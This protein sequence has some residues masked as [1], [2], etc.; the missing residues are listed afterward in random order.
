MNARIAA[1]A[2]SLPEGTLTNEE[3]ARGNPDWSP[4]KILLKTGIACRHIAAP[5]DTA[6]DLAERAAKELFAAGS[7]SP[8]DIDF[9]LLCTQSPDYYL[10]A[11]ACILQDRLGVPKS[12]G[13]L[14]FN[15][16]CS[17]YVY[18]LSLAKGLIAAGIARRVLLLTA[19]TYSRYIEPNDWSTRSLFGDGAAAT[20][21]EA[22]ESEGIGGF[23]LG[24]DGSG[25][26]KLVVR[27][28]AHR[29]WHDPEA[30]KPHLEMSGPDIFSFA[31]RTVPTV[32]NQCLKK[33]GLEKTDIDV[34]AL[35]QANKFMLDT[36][37]KAIRVAP[38]KLPIRMV[39]CGNTVSASLPI[40]LDELL[41]DG[42]L[43][44]GKRA[45]L[46]GF[47][48]GLSWGAVPVIF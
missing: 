15:Q 35:H 42:T 11:T 6:A 34:F 32:V 44:P 30:T 29:N 38:E 48:V 22:C 28:G 41:T 12:A 47:G 36:L 7:C 1:I 16:G 2:T 37:C 21:V 3:L 14:D 9:V 33:A 39:N 43:G 27:N 25:W 20:L 26:D 13:A 10:P 4:E 24:T 45:L 18:G 46:V 19:E 40:L 17:G 8:D 5:D 23:V 31:L